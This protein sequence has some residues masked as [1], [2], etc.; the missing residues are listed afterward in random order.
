M[1]SN[2]LYLLAFLL[3]MSLVAK[4]F[5]A[6]GK[7]ETFEEARHNAVANAIKFSVGEYVE[8]NEVLKDD[9]INQR[10][11]LYSN[12][13]IKHSKILSQKKEGD[14]YIVNVEVD[15]DKQEIVGVL[16]TIENT[17]STMNKGLSIKIDNQID[18]YQYNEKMLEILGDVIEEILVNPVL[19]GKTNLTI[20][21]GE[22][23]FIKVTENG[24]L[25]FKYPVKFS[26]DRDYNK[27][28]QAI[29]KEVQGRGETIQVNSYRLSSINKETPLSPINIE[30]KKIEILSEKFVESSPEIKYIRKCEKQGRA[31]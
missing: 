23:D 6:V 15:L 20:E 22:L 9:D 14:E 12:A 17:S 5:E 11:T 13:Y 8:S 4:P 1:K 3:P 21:P 26:I 2:L 28:V 25:L 10:V 7:G 31:L 27:A 16:K 30:K 29:L 24:E 18:A 19:T